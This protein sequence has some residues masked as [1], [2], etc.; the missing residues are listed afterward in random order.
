MV[1]SFF[2]S[3]ADAG[4]AFSRRSVAAVAILTAFA[5]VPLLAPMAFAQDA[6]D[7]QTPPKKKKKKPKAAPSASATSD[8]KAAAAASSAPPPE[9]AP[10]AAP[11]PEPSASAASSASPSE[12]KALPDN[13]TAGAYDASDT[14]ELPDKTY[15]FVGLR[16]RANVIPQA[17][18]NL[19]TDEGATFTSNSFGAELDI[20]KGNQSTIPWIQYTDFNTGDILFLQKGKD[21]GNAAFY[22]LINS[23]LK[24]V[25]A[26]VDELWSVGDRH[27]AF[28]FGFGVGIGVIFGSLGDNWVYANNNGPIVASN[29]LHLAPCPPSNGMNQPFGC[30][31]GDHQGATT[32]KV[33]GYNEANW[34]SGGPVPVFLPY[35][36]PEIG[37]RY[38]PIKQL[39]TRLSVGFSLTG[40]WF[41]LSAD[42]GLERKEEE[43]PPGAHKASFATSVHDTL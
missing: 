19:F 41:G 10:S 16:Y 2:S 25:Y 11:L 6:T 35:L 36:S 18:V 29:G 21:A 40:V 42:Y 34:F 17:L 12:P 15:L 13:P 8:D 32:P 30:N 5:S 37:L 20:R 31:V 22:S 27:L 7:T 3:A 1:R 14:T 26:G 28:E 39:E 43:T 33:G 9:P 4:R 38:K 24:S 23:S